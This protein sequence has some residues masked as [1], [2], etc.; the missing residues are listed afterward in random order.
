MDA[1]SLKNPKKKYLP[2]SCLLKFQGGLLER[3]LGTGSEF[4]DIGENG[5]LGRPGQKKTQL[6]SPTINDR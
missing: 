4:G 3:F 5:S 1:N 6:L 2:K